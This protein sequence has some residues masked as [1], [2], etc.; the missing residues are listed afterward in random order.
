MQSAAQF[1]ETNNYIQLFEVYNYK[2]Y[3]SNVYFSHL[4][5]YNNEVNVNFNKALQ[6]SLFAFRCRSCMLT[7][8]NAEHFKAHL[9]NYYVNIYS[10]S[11]C[12]RFFSLKIQLNEH[13]QAVKHEKITV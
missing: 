11:I 12:L 5:N 8:S 3:N 13:L 10:Y 4:S 1:S 2:E 7:F 9:Q 6:Y